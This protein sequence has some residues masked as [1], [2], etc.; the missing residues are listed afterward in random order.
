M[1]WV[2]YDITYLL[3]VLGK[4]ASD[5]DGY[6]K[7]D[8]VFNW[9]YVLDMVNYS[10]Y[11]VFIYMRLQALQMM[12]CNPVFV[13]VNNYLTIFE[14]IFNLQQQ[15][16]SINYISV[17]LGTFRFFKYY[18]FQ[19]RLQI[20]NKTL[21]SSAI[22]LFHFLI[23]FGVILVGFALIGHLNFGSQVIATV[24]RASERAHT[25]TRAH[26]RPHWPPGR[27]LPGHAYISTHP[28][29]LPSA[30]THRHTR[31]HALIGRLDVG[32]QVMHTSAHTHARTHARTHAHT[33]ARTPSLAS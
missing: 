12:V 13:P 25:Q 2:F 16:L 28:H 27:W 18:Q 23:V 19:P 11:L 31:T 22:H 33:H 26:T 8:E 6:Q 30:R 24:I 9:W 17:L 29:L 3:V 21:A 4:I 14:D 7:G 20:V 10:C 15:Q 32:S 1:V 5:R